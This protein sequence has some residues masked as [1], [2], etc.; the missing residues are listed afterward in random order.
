MVSCDEAGSMRAFA[1]IAFMELRPSNSKTRRR[2]L[3]ADEFNLVWDENKVL[4]IGKKIITKSVRG[5][6]LTLRT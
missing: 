1:V 4:K 2:A 3:L 6:M 5:T